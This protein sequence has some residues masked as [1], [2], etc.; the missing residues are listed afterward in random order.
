MTDLLVRNLDEKTLKALRLR[1][2]AEGRSV[3]AE[4]KAILTNGVC[5]KP[6]KKPSLIESLRGIAKEVGG[7]DDVVIPS[8]MA[9]REPPTF[10]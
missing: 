4:A 10:D 5:L 2:S 3:S 6:R 8:R 7:F 9:G 1:A